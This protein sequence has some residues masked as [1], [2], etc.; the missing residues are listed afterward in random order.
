VGGTPL[1]SCS[2]G[3]HE[4]SFSNDALKNTL[5]QVINEDNSYYQIKF[6]LSSATDSDGVNDVLRINY[7]EAKLTINYTAD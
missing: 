6:G 3:L 1:T 2:T 4:F 5:Q 7:C